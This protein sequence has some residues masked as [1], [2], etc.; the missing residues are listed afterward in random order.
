MKDSLDGFNNWTLE[1]LC[2]ICERVVDQSDPDTIYMTD[3]TSLDLENSRPTHR[4]C[5][6]A[7]EDITL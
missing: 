4:G 2:P 5:L 7:R 1:S 3:V 6:E